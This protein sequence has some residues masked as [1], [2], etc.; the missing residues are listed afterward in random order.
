MNGKRDEATA[1]AEQWP[2]GLERVTSKMCDGCGRNLVAACWE[3][4]ATVF[5]T[6]RSPRESSD[7][8]LLAWAQ[9]RAHLLREIKRD[10]R[11]RGDLDQRTVDSV[12]GHLGRLWNF[13]WDT[14]PVADFFA[15]EPLP[16]SSDPS[17]MRTAMNAD[18]RDDD[19]TTARGAVLAIPREVRHE[20]V[21]VDPARLSGSPC[22]GSTRVPVY[23]VVD[24]VWEHGV[25]EAMDTWD[26]TLGEVLNACW[27]AATVNVVELWGPNGL[28][29]SRGPWRKRWGVWAQEV[30]RDLWRQDYRAVKEPPRRGENTS[31]G[32]VNVPA[33]AENSFSTSDSSGTA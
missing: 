18:K 24:F 13:P 10:A 12:C 17:S 20:G 30:H 29:T 19:E 32:L 6:P 9:F 1:T 21:E 11:A 5:G 7:A 23:M 22:C 16:E 3:C 2:H 14:G 15:V 8:A 4:D 31:R 25:A 28:R 33:V 27:Y 26:L